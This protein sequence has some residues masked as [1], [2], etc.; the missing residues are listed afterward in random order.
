MTSEMR[1]SK[2]CNEEARIVD[3]DIFYGCSEAIKS[4]PESEKLFFACSLWD[5]GLKDSCNSCRL[6]CKN[7]DNKEFKKIAAQKKELRV[8]IEDLRPNMMLYGISAN[9][10]EKISN[11]YTKK[12]ADGEV[13]Q[14]GAEGIRIANNANKLLRMA[15][16]GKMVNPSFVGAYSKYSQGRLKKLIDKKRKE[17]KS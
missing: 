13:D 10:V 12:G 4:E 9:Q 8:L 5:M 6:A 3:G 14:I 1:N 2:Y 16:D 7:N 11:V 17:D 15:M